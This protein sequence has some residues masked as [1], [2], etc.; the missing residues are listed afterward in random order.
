MSAHALV[1]M[2]LLASPHRVA[3]N[4]CKT[5]AE[6]GPRQFCFQ[7]AC[8][9][10]GTCRARPEMCA[11]MFDPVCGCDGKTYTNACAANEGGTSKAK[12]GAC[13]EAKPQCT[14][15]AD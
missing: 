2:L 14:T 1:L 13:S 7:K 10:E 6:C 9:L 12:K 15:A 8:G 5:T 4:S 11:E 3:A